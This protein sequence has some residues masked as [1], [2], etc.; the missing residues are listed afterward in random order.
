MTAFT[1]H[2]AI[3][4]M[5]WVFTGLASIELV[6]VHLLVS[7][8]HPRVALA[9]SLISLAGLV[10]LIWAIVVMRRRPVLIGPDALVMRAGGFKQVRVL[11]DAI[12]AVSAAGNERDR[13]AL[14]LALIAH[15]NVLVELRAPLPGRRMTRR[16]AH[17]LDDPQG[18]IATLDAAI[19]G[20]PAP[21]I[22][23]KAGI[24]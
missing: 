22:P 9:L 17:R 2:R 24:H 5:L 15:P 21:V 11:L 13:S 1:Y 4:P 6:V 10:W 3:A 20:R 14:N 18:F 19:R 23:A 8:W 7:F 16:I 12:A